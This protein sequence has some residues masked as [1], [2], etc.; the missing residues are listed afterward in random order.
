M[1][2]HYTL[3][4]LEDRVFCKTCNAFTQHAVSGG[5]LGHCIRCF[6]RR[7]QKEAAR[8]ALEAAQ[9][10]FAFGGN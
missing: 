9:P 5:R 7:Q 2:K 4:T 3:G 8:K 1:A 10:A 6:D